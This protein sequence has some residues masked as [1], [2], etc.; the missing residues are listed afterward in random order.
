MKIILFIGVFLFAFVGSTQQLAFNFS[1]QITNADTKKS[2]AGVTVSI[3]GGGKTLASSQ[4]AS[5]G[6]YNFETDAPLGGII[7]VVFSKAGFVSKKIDINTSKINV[8]DLPAGDVQDMILPGELF[9]EKADID[10][11]FLKTE[12]VALFF[13]DEV[14]HS[15]SLDPSVSTKSKKKIADALAAGAGN[16]AATEAKYKAAIDAGAALMNQKKYEEALTKYEAAL[17]IK[18]KEALPTQKISELDKLIKDQKSANLAGQ[19]AELEYKN[20]ISAADNLRDQKKYQEASAKYSE[21]LKKK[22]DPYPTGEINKL[23]GLIADQKSQ[24]SKDLQ[25]DGLKKEGMDLAVAKKWSESKTKLNQALAIKADPVITAKIKEIDIELGKAVSEKEKSDKYNLLMSTADGFLVSGK[26]NEAKTKYTEALT[27]DP[28]QTLPKTKIAEVNDLIAKKS[29]NSAKQLK[30]DKLILE[31]NT[32]FAKNDLAGSKIKFE[33]VLKE[34]ATNEIAKLKLKEISA[35]LDSAKGQAEKDAQFE[36]LKKEGM[37][38]AASKKWNEA[39]IKLEQAVSVKPDALI[40][41]KLVEIKAALQA[42]Q[43]QA[44]LEEDFKRLM[45]EA[46]KQEGAKNYDAA[47]LKYKE[48]SSKK[49]TEVLPKTKISELEKLKASA[50]SS[51]QAELQ[52]TA[53]YTSSMTKGNKNLVDKKYALALTDFQ[54]A[55]AAKSGDANAQSKISETQQILDDLANANSKKT[56]VKK[57]FDKAMSDAKKL[58]DQKKYVD[59]KKGYELALTIIENDPNAIKQVSECQRLS[60]IQS[61]NEVN[62]EYKKIVAAADRKLNDKDYIKA[63]DYYERALKL[64]LTDPYPKS[65]LDE[66]ER[67]LNPSA[68]I[69]QQDVQPEKL[70]DL[71]I[72][73]L[74]SEVAARAE[75]E[76]A[77]IARKTSKNQNFKNSVQV[78][79]DFEANRTAEKQEQS[80]ATTMTVSEIQEA[81]I[82]RSDANIQD[83]SAVIKL[84]NDVIKEQTDKNEEDIA[85]ENSDHQKIDENFNLIEEENTADYLIREGVFVD[86]GDLIKKHNSEYSDLEAKRTKEYEDKN[87][88]T[89]VSILHIEENIIAHQQDDTESRIALDDRIEKAIL[90]TIETDNE[91]TTDKKNQ[92]LK[93]EIE[94]TEAKKDSEDQLIVDEVNAVKMLTD[95]EQL[96]ENVNN[97][98][99]EGSSKD[100]VDGMTATASMVDINKKISEQESVNKGTQ[101]AS[102]TLFQRAHKELDDGDVLAYNNEMLKHLKNKNI[103]KEKTGDNSET[104]IASNEKLI[105]NNLLIKDRANLLDDQNVEQ[106]LIN[107]Q[108]HLDATQSIHDKQNEE[109]IAK[110]IVANA[111]GAEYPEGVSQEVFSVNDENGLMKSIVTRRVVVVGGNGSVYVKTETTTA[112]TFS[113]NNSPTTQN[114]W[115]KETQGPN[116]KKNY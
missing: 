21:A 75:L 86:K 76:K 3:I 97:S 60:E 50:A 94:I 62:V 89:K 87:V 37:A 96:K 18:P 53:L 93:S 15:M 4:T 26:L 22:S 13:W 19:Q 44:A 48:A 16:A 43:S 20:L 116:L 12:P 63:K 17:I 82:A 64:R 68:P 51:N 88:D 42:G 67:L 31:G 111:L 79:T 25:F 91:K 45:G 46:S 100:E 11:S 83:L 106:G 54:N 78:V 27:L 69:V 36:A 92:N 110:P 2:E 107:D 7:Q 30:I 85:F 72:P 52:K 55:L 40:S 5:N 29:V 59:A 104:T 8:E 108:K 98:D 105:A 49:P 70:E 28:S 101:Q 23:T 103:L 57:N 71:G 47:I 77:E 6:K 112:T 99:Q 24:A 95:L 35:K 84:R 102:N 9:T 115:Q 34:E 66:I 39:K 80:I 90:V 74:E 61:G 41:Q 32:A 38:L 33:E 1:G 114:V 56:E 58:F 81:V 109:N 65:K 113:K 73:F 14:S 10:F